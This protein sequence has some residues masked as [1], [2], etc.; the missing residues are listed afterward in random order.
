MFGVAGM[1]R[2]GG[3]RI[4]TCMSW[5]M[6]DVFCQGLRAHIER[7]KTRLRMPIGVEK[8]V[9]VTIWKLATNVEYQT[10]LALFGLGRCTV[11]VI[12]VETCNAITKH[13]FPWYVSF[14]MGERLRDIVRMIETCWGF[15]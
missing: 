15:P 2:H 10:L 3:R 9:V 4:C 11:C 13:L 7:Q 1:V 8:R 5:N 12:V 6:F 14:P